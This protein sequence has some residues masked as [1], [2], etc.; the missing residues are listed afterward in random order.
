[1]SWPGRH[2]QELVAFLESAWFG[3]FLLITGCDVNLHISAGSELPTSEFRYPAERPKLIICN[4][5]SQVDAL[6]IWMLAGQCNKDRTGHVKVLATP[7]VS[8]LLVTVGFVM[9]LSVC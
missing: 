1:M 8:H 2:K 4:H 3:M 7:T 6:Y 9:R 5:T